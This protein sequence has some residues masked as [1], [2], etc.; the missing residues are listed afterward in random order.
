MSSIGAVATQEPIFSIIASANFN[1]S[2]TSLSDGH[3]Y[4]YGNL[5]ALTDHWNKEAIGVSYAYL[6]NYCI[7]D[8][9][10]FRND[11]CTIRRGV[12]VTSIR[13]TTK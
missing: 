13:K 10:A 5:K 2:A 7:S 8:E 12:I 1:L 4:Y 11:K 6:R 3:H 9:K